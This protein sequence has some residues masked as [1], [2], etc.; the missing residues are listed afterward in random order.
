VHGASAGNEED[1]AHPEIRKP[2]KDVV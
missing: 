2:L 1:V